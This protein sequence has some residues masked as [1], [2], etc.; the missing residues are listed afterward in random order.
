MSKGKSLFDIFYKYKNV[1]RM[2]Q[3]PFNNKNIA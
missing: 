3:M 1:G 2:N